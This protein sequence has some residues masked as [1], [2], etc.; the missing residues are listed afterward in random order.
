MIFVD[1]ASLETRSPIRYRPS[2][3][4]AFRLPLE[5]ES[6]LNLIQ[7]YGRRRKS[8]FNRKS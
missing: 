1:F 4:R 2:F 3:L 6:K 7:I 5:L 8:F